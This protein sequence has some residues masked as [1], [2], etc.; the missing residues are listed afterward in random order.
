M[1]R[2]N[3]IL[4]A[5]ALI[6][7]SLT[8]SPALVAQENENRDEYGR[9]VRGPYETNR[10]GDNWFIS[11]GGGI[12]AFWN[13]NLTV[14]NMKIAP[15]VDANFGKWFTPAVGMRV[16]Y[17]GI[18]SQVWSPA[19]TVLGPTLDTDKGMYLEK[20]GYMYV[21]GD[22]LWNAS[23]AIGGYK[24]TRFWN[25]IPYLHAG[26]Y[27]SYGLDDVDFAD[28]E[29][30]AGV[31]L[32]HNLRLA[33][34]LDLVIDM[35]ATAV[36]GRARAADGVAVIPSVTM[37]L[38]VDLGWP[39]FIRSSTVIAG[40]EVVMAEQIAAVE[41]AAVALEVANMSL[42]EQNDALTAANKKLKKENT[43]L[44]GRPVYDAQEFFKDMGPATVYFNIGQAV[45][46]EKELNHLDY[47]ATNI[48]SKADQETMIYITV[49]GTADSSTGTAK[50]NQYL[51]KARGEYVYD[52]L[53]NKYGI[54]PE[55][56]IVDSEVVQ[57]PET[58]AL[59]RAVIIK[60]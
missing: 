30:A 50:R 35:R 28:N 45:L 13:E 21:H 31:G 7:V 29:L 1:K 4:G 49:L 57:S 47:V 22:F 33:D 20:F 43:A 42:K 51:S 25:L 60:F 27:R 9:I 6:A 44:K 34:R 36:N 37:G 5:V 59:D 8:A 23:D 56:I 2:L 39:G 32:L 14:D 38:S 19:S 26:Y 55:R 10:F 53:V 17:Q 18:N 16:G 24:E 52:L 3:L 11:V 54:S 58:P 15:S 48:L 40:V 12:N 41:A 46:S